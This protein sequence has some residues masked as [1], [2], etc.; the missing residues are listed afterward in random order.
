M[1]KSFKT[2]VLIIGGG[3]AGSSAACELAKNGIGTLIVDSRK[4]IGI[5]VQC[6]EF[7]PIQLMQKPFEDYFKNSIIQDVKNMITLDTLN[8]KTITDSKGVMVD[9]TIFDKNIFQKAIN[10]GAK[11]MLKTLF[12]GFSDK[13]KAVL[14]NKDGTFEI[15]FD[16]LIGADGPK[17]MVM[18]KA[19]DKKHKLATCAQLRCKLNDMLEDIIVVFRPYIRGGYGWVFPKGDYANVGIGIDTM[20]GDNPKVVLD[21]F[22]KEMVYQGFIKNECDS[23]SGGFLPIDGIGVLVK[24]NIALVGDAG[25]FCHPITGGGIPQ[26][27][28]SGD[29]LAKYII[30]GDLFS[31]KEEA[32]DIFGI[33]NERAYKKRKTYMQDWNNIQY[34][35]PYIWV[36]YEEYWKSV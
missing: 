7:I 4:E 27:V 36:A 34:I 33:A 19:F 20:Y 31:Y 24:D 22:I 17:S 30:E 2:N 1:P 14:K 28:L 35:L 21:I 32:F 13:N 26:A 29:M 23:A 5:P 3:L 16:Y 10:Y 6:A 25:G 15:E 8:N 18:E 9:R 11:S 12:V